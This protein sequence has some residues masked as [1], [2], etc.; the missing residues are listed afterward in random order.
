VKK[1]NVLYEREVRSKAGHNWHTFVEVH[2]KKNKLKRELQE[3][4]KAQ[5]ALRASNA[6]EEDLGSKEAWQA[7]KRVRVRG[8]R[9]H[10]TLRIPHQHHQTT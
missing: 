3:Q 7:A 4:Y 10:P 6:W 8:H 1:F 2:K 9:Q 5:L